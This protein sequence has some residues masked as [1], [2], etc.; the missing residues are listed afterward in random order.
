MKK[1]SLP[2][3]NAMRSATYFFFNCDVAVNQIT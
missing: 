1:A 2:L 3:P